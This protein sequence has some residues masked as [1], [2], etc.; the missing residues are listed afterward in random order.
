MAL[1]KVPPFIPLRIR[2]DSKLITEGFTTHLKSWENRGWI[3]VANATKLQEIAARL[4]ARSAPTWFKWVKGHS[5]DIG[6]DGAD[7]LAKAGA[8]N[9]EQPELPMPTELGGFLKKGMSLVKLTQKLAYQ[10]VKAWKKTPK[11]K[12]TEIMVGRIQAT[13][14]DEWGTNVNAKK[15]WKSIRHPDMRRTLRDFWWKATHDALRIGLYWKNIPGYEH[16]ELCSHCNVTESLEHI[17]LECDAPGQKTIWEAVKYIT[18]K[19]EIE[20]WTMSLGTLLATPAMNSW[21]KSNKGSKWDTRLIKIVVTESAHLIWKIRCERVIERSGEPESY[22][23]IQEIRNRW[24]DA[25]NKRLR[26][27]QDL[28]HPRIKR[29]RIEPKIVHATWKGVLKDEAALPDEWFTIKGV[30]VGKPRH[31]LRQD[32]G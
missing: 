29:G 30:L 11:R 15:L 19:K 28:A 5:D 32:A 8:L 20:P 23:T 12:K 7:V 21:S 26:L 25:I 9:Q 10:G 6:N 16:R 31:W 18:R 22:H 24:E 3:N 1:K 4:R 2:S 14:R 13:I 27:D 17:M